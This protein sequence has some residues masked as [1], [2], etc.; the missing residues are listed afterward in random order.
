MMGEVMHVVGAGKSLYLPVKFVLSLKLLYKNKILKNNNK[1]IGGS[2]LL[3]GNGR[4]QT[5]KKGGPRLGGTPNA[6]EL[7]RIAFS[8]SAGFGSCSLIF[9]N[10]KPFSNCHLGHFQLKGK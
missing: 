3:I 5:P 8:L 9:L 10:N 2:P 1:A 7:H 6:G 4:I